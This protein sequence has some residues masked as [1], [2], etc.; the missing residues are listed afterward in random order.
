MTLRQLVEDLYPPY[1]EEQKRVS[2][3][4]GYLYMWR[5]H[6]KPRSE[7]ALRDFRTVDA[8]NMLR[9]IARSENLNRVSL[10]HLKAFLSGAFRYARRQGILNTEN[11]IRDVVL[12]KATRDKTIQA[13]LRHSNLTTTMNTYVKSV[14]ADA[15]AAMRALE[16]LCNQHATTVSSREAAVM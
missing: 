3:Y 4:K 15:T 8:E 11:P 12:P 9:A 5:R 2:T 13:I 10:A 1:V 6:L 7:L 14:S 16:E